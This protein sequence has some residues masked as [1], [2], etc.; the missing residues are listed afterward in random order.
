MK[1]LGFIGTGGMGTGYTW[2]EISDTGGYAHLISAAAQWV[3]YLEGKTD[4]E[5]QHV[6]VG[7]NKGNRP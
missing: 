2:D 7:D 6:P 4:W 5:T 1:T 3:F